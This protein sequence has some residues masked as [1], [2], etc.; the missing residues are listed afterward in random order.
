MAQFNGSSSFTLDW[1]CSK[2]VFVANERTRIQIE[3]VNGE[4]GGEK[5]R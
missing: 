4:G 3:V 2:E 5:K 1:T